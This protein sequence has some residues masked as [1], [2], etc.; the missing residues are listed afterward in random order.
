MVRFV[1]RQHLKRSTTLVGRTTLP[2]FYERGE[3]SP[4]YHKAGWGEFVQRFGH[5]GHRLKLIAGMTGAMN[6]LRQAGCPAVYIDES[7]VTGK[8]HP[9]DYDGCWDETG[10]DR[11]LLDPVLP[12]FN[13]ERGAQKLKYM[14]KFFPAHYPARP[15]GIP[16]KDFF[17]IDRMG[18]PKG[19]VEIDLGELNDQG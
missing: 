19:I 5:T 17:Q 6:S 16:Y 15:D 12:D 11:G 8:I 4:G 14:G 3:L 2:E 10:V 9:Q 13:Y 18:A 7:F 1:I